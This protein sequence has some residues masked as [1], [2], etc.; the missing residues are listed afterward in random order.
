MPDECRQRVKEP[1]KGGAGRACKSCFEGCGICY[2][3]S[4][5]AVSYP[6]LPL[7]ARER[8]RDRD[9]EKRERECVCI[10]D[11]DCDCERETKAVIGILVPVALL[12]LLLLLLLWLSV[13]ATGHNKASINNKFRKEKVRKPQ[14]DC[15]L[16]MYGTVYFTI[17]LPFT[18]PTLNCLP[19]LA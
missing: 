8:E 10:C 19:D 16:P 6:E 17:L 12:L 4:S 5:S 3:C 18:Y 15:Q 1:G 14:N 11:C 9:R 7:T 13:R 2:C